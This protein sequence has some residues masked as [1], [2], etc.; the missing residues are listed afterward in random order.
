MR[1]ELGFRQKL[2]FLCCGTVY[3]CRYQPSWGT[4]MYLLNCTASVSEFSNYTLIV[5]GKSLLKPFVPILL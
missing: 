4:Y 1:L 2:S 3:F 5:G